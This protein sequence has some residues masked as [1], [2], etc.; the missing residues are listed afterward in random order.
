MSNRLKIAVPFE[1]ETC[2]EGGH[3][4]YGV[5]VV[6]TERTVIN[7]HLYGE[8]VIF[9]SMR[10][11]DAVATMLPEVVPDESLITAAVYGRKIDL[12]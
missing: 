2:R 11:A 9:D 12:N 8:V 10:E 1:L 5:M 6:A 3:A 7:K 4:C